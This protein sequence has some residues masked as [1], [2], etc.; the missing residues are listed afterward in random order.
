MPPVNLIL[1]VCFLTILVLSAGCRA[2]TE[3]EFTTVRLSDRVLTLSSLTGNSR[4]VAISSEKG[5]VLIDT[6]WSP[7]A[8]REARDIIEREFG[9]EDFIYIINANAQDLSSRGNAAF[10]GVAVI[11]HED[12]RESLAG[13]LEGPDA[14][15]A[16]RADE[17]HDRVV[18][19]E[20]QLEEL[21]PGSDRAISLQN[22]IDLC[23]R[24][25]EDMRQGYDI[26]L[27]EITFSDRMSIDLG[28]MMLELIYFGRTGNHG[29]IFVIVPEE[30]L[31]FLSDVFHAGH[32]LPDTRGDIRE[33]DVD[34]W[35]E[36]L[37]HVL[38]R[39]DGLR[40]I[41]R[42]NGEDVWTARRVGEHLE[43]IRGV[44][45]GVEAA[46]AAGLSMEEAIEAFS[47]VD[48]KYPFVR[49]WVSYEEYGE[50]ILMMDIGNMVRLLWRQTHA[51]AASELARILDDQGEDAARA[52]FHGMR[53]A[54]ESGYYLSEGE[55]NS[56]GYEYL[57]DGRIPE[58]IAMFKFAVEAFPQ[59]ANVY[60]S[61]GEGYKAAG[62]KQLAIDNYRRS[63]ELNPENTNAVEMLRELDEM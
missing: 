13:K 60:D 12:C 53:S 41:I 19:S 47:P 17:F 22:W 42:A 46:D 39:G 57:R 63:L 38:A 11:G 58:A 20:A 10:P 28:D 9:R 54:A 8:A 50:R 4:A 18:R 30:G 44:R 26:V 14:D 45:R 33:A 24:I 43:L 40:H 52:A 2:E 29:D 61:L 21:E 31:V 37:E 35:V 62:R 7:R 27:P 56:K 59:S 3:L 51:S 55:F 48:E 6:F 34:R 49:N 32:T 25:E 23:R 16:R 5:L 1:K 36:S 15:L